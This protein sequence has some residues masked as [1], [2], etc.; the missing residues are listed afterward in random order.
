[1]SS[2]DLYEDDIA[3]PPHTA[4]PHSIDL[5]LE[6]EHQLDIESVPSSPTFSQARSRPQ[7]LDPHILASIITQLRISLT[8]VTKERDDLSMMLA[9]T[10]SNEASM[11][12]AL[13][14]LADKCVRLETELA[15][16]MEKN[17]EDTD[18]IAMLRGKLEDSR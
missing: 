14:H 15:A 1:M 13:H 7:S 18:A 6:L 8:E 11:K 10:Q 9:E 16:S 12:D 17:K 5:T 3:N 2:S 4:R